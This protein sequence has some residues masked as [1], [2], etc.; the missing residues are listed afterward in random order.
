MTQLLVIAELLQCIDIVWYLWAFIFLGIILTSLGGV[1]IGSLFVG[2]LATIIAL[3]NLLDLLLFHND[4][5]ESFAEMT[6]DAP[7]PF[8][9]VPS[10]LSP[11]PCIGVSGLVASW[12]PPAANPSWKGSSLTGEEGRLGVSMPKCGRGEQDGSFG[13]VEVVGEVLGELFEVTGIL[14]YVSRLLGDGTGVVKE[15]MTLRSE[16]SDLYSVSA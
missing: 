13:N 2:T 9:L 1:R 10:G 14:L 15:G 5:H 8:D 16:R 7:L 12:P 6:V 11:V 4:V 3:A